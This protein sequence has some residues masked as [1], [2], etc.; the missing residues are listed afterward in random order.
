MEGLKRFSLTLSLTNRLLY[1]APC[2]NKFAIL[3]HFLYLFRMQN[4]QWPAARRLIV[5]HPKQ[6]IESDLKW[7]T[8]QILGRMK[9]LI[10]SERVKPIRQRLPV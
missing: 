6:N 2:Q 7:Q 10:V 1:L 3:D 5:L 9:Q 8:C 4:D